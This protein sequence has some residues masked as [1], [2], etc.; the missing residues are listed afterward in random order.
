MHLG[1]SGLLVRHDS[2]F[3]VAAVVD[4]TAMPWGKNNLCPGYRK[5]TSH[6]ING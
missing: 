5:D 2:F 3:G 4:D 6:L 1:Q